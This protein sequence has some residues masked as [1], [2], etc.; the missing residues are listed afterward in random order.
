MGGKAWTKAEDDWLKQ[1]SENYATKDALYHAFQLIFPGRRGVEGV[2]SRTQVLGIDRSRFMSVTQFGNTKGRSL[3]VGTERIAYTTGGYKA[4]YVKVKET[5]DC[6]EHITRYAEPYWKVKQK[7]I[8]EDYYGEIPKGHMVVFLDQNPDNYDINN[9]YCIS[10]KIL[11]R[12][13]QNRWFTTDREHTLTAIKWCEL[14]LV[15]KERK[16]NGQQTG[17]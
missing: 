2:K 4:V 16:N 8:Y 1:N 14:F 17:D 9:L 12:M 11:V 6:R 3:P 13:N 5:E 15:L 10:R 7:K